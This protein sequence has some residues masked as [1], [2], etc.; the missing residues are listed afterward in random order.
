M[1]S[2]AARLAA[3]RG[4]APPVNHDARTLAGLSA[5]PGCARRALLDACG[6]DKGKIA[7]RAGH[8]WQFGMSPF[9][10]ARGRDFERRLKDNGAALLLALLRQELE[11]P[12]EEVAYVPLETVG[13]NTGRE[14]RHRNTCRRLLAAPAGRE[15]GTLFDHPLLRLQIGGVPV[16]LEPDLVALKAAGRFHV[17]EIKSFPVIDGRADPEHAA[18]AVKQ[19]AVYVV[20]LQEMFAEHGVDPDVVATSVVLVTPK[21]FGNTPTATQVDAR[22]QIATIR[23][24]LR[25]MR[26]V[27]EL[28][29][30]LPPGL[31]FDL[32]PDEC[33]RPTR[34]PEELTAH[35][36][37]VPSRYRPG[38]IA[39]CELAGLCRSEAR[40]RGSLD[41][42]GPDV[43]DVLGGIDTVEAALA[44]AEGTRAPTEEQADI[45][46]A[47][48]HAERLRAEL[49]GEPARPS[50]PGTEPAGERA[51]R[52][53]A[54]S[55]GGAA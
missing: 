8:P 2:A 31:T 40:E 48:R 3:L 12:L 19:A 5:N 38:C 50:R 46:R 10:L 15:P 53:P 39:R 7:R 35:L 32:A 43:A 28:L 51:E 18:A 23:R 41:V 34:P 21:N 22:K 36:R 25:R 27:E 9:A 11:L 30:P 13:D 14:L 17:V 24:Q 45:A 20:A 4:A 16:Y 49:A 47:L 29:E 37:Q 6:A 52:P 1:D 54:R 44:L 33:G 42:F 26:R 55:A